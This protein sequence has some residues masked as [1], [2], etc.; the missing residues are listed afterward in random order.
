MQNTIRTHRTAAQLLNT[1]K[2]E[3]EA[4]KGKKGTPELRNQ[5]AKL[6][7]QFD[8]VCERV[9]KKGTPDGARREYE[10]KQSRRQAV[11]EAIERAQTAVVSRAGQPSFAYGIK[12]NVGGGFYRSTYNELEPFADCDARRMGD[13]SHKSHP[14]YAAVLAPYAVI[15]KS[16]TKGALPAEYADFDSKGR[17]E[18][19]NI[20]LYGFNK[21]GLVCVQVRETTITKYGSSPKKTYYVTDGREAIEVSAQKVR[22][23]INNDPTADSAL[24]AV[25][26]DMPAK[27]QRKIGKKAPSLANPVYTRKAFKVLA[28]TVSGPLVSVYDDSVYKPVTWRSQKA[29]EE[30]GGGF[31]VYLSPDSAKEAAQHN[32][33]FASAWTQGKEL[34]LCEVETRGTCVEYASGKHAFSQIRVLREIETIEH[35]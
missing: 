32:E 9:G 28:R 21:H 18:C 13:V 30:H 11:C 26:A 35:N 20:D 4:A 16:Q 22:R 8:A 7:A 27:W 31:Y 10:A 5:L 15:A 14:V 33:I 23:A 1:K 25:R 24:R 19:L 34:V 12:P 17:G 2:R 6:C 3:V 29:R